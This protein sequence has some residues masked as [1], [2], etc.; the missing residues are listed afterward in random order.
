MRILLSWLRDFVDVGAAPAALGEMLTARGFEVA[1]IEEMPAGPAFILMD[2][3]GTRTSPGGVDAVLDLEI[4]ANRPDCLSVVGI[5]REVATAF[6]EPLTPAG[7]AGDSPM[8]MAF[9]SALSPDGRATGESGG[10]TVVLE[11]PDRCPRYAAGV[12]DVKIGPSPDWLAN[13]LIAAGLRP[14]NNVVDVTNY[15]LIETGHPLHAFDLARLAGHTLR[16]RAARPGEQLRT[17]D[18]EMRTL[19]ADMLVIAD[20]ERAQAIAGVMGGAASEVWNGTTRIALESA[21][22]KP[23]SVRRTSKRLGLKTEASARFERGADIE[24]PSSALL[25]AL[26]LLAQIG[27]GRREREAE[28]LIDCYPAR[29]PRTQVL[30]RRA[31]IGHLLG[32]EIP[33]DT[34]VRMLTGL[35]FRPEAT[36][37]GWRTTVPS[38]RVDVSREVDLIEEVARHDGYDRIPNTFPAQTTVPARS[39]ARIDRDALVRRVL[40]AAGFSEA[41]TFAFIEAGAATAFAGGVEPVPI[42]Y[43]LSENFA[44]LRPSLLPGLVDSIAYNR[45]RERRHVRLFEI[46]STFSAASGE[47]RALAFG[48]SGTAVPEHWGGGARPVD[49]FDIKG[50]AER[51]AAA[52]QVPVR[53]RPRV[54]SCLVDGRAASVMH[55][56]TEVGVLGQ[57]APGVAQARDLPA[58]EDVY[59]AEFDLDRLACQAPLDVRAE[60]L[61]RHPSVGRDL[62][63]IVAE[64]LPAEAVRGTIVAAA[65][66]TLVA[67]CEFDRYKGKGI[68]EGQVSLSLHLTFR[69]AE[70]TLTDTEVQQAMDAIVDA[71]GREHRAVRR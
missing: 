27:A 35:G 13:R 12:A 54:L 47:R 14:I 68:A 63:I 50:V 48:W 25:R 2:E 60:P 34:V 67:L 7:A 51:V 19:D 28:A 8:A 10:L 42:A 40:A 56:E 31:R 6:Q 43:P 32:R 46:G 71:L 21:Y 58:G 22:F 20:A 23:S 36:T 5:A 24:A 66:T 26:A 65:P 62:S 17:L 52:L 55:G 30:L 29:R 64:T 15:V 3:H 45:R 57:L 61:P 1:S 18:G 41:Q 53:F 44:V 16:I 11:D 4:T 70:R 37:D 49:L 69:A 39:D 38:W 59:V 9:G 33:D